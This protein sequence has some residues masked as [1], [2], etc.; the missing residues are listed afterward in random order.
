VKKSLKE[1]EKEY[2]IKKE[3]L[4]LEKK[5]REEEHKRFKKIFKKLNK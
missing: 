5:E 4:E 2:K 3:I 1:L